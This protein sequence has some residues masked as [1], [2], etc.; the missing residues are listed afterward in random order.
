MTP[1][2]PRCPSFSPRSLPRLARRSLK[3][4]LCASL[5][6]CSALPSTGPRPPSGVFRAPLNDSELEVAEVAAQPVGEVL[7]KQFCAL[8]T[9]GSRSADDD[10][11]WFR[12]SA[13]LRGRPP[14]EI[15]R[16]VVGAAPATENSERR[17]WIGSGANSRRSVA[18]FCHWSSMT[19]ASWV[20]SS[21]SD[22][23]AVRANAFVTSSARTIRMPRAARRTGRVHWRR[24]APTSSAPRTHRFVPA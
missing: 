11:V 1:G 23:T 13:T 4:S 7:D 2:R 3:H 9:S 5:R 21:S 16:E 10:R 17:Q 6:R 8:P 22:S 15:P 24:C 20:V 12:G 18:A 14:H 19:S